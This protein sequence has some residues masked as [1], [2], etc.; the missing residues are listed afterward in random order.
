MPTESPL[1][2][3]H[4]EVRVAGP[5]DVHK[6]TDE[7]DHVLC[8]ATV[9][10]VGAVPHGIDAALATAVVWRPEVVAF[11][12]A[13][14]QKLKA[15]DWKPGWKKDHPDD[16]MSRVYQELNECRGA[17][18]TYKRHKADAAFI[19][20]PAPEYDAA[21]AKLAVWRGRL[22][23]EAADVANML[24]MVCDVCAALTTTPES[25]VA[26]ARSAYARA[27]GQN[28]VIWA[29]GE[30]Q[31]ALREGS[32]VDGDEGDEGSTAK[33]QEPGAKRAPNKARGSPPEAQPTPSQ[34]TKE[35]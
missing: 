9:S 34:P 29:S 14:E 5:D 4:Y 10:R 3:T 30:L 35:I 2:L 23:M 8:L 26:D 16:L 1:P 18:D 25:R 22:L 12:D 27:T 11:A 13:M 19:P 7:L 6:H 21:L 20:R 32:I 15:N 17:L 28:E 33:P 24:M 31:A